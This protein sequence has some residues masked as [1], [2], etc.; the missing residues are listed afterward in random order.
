MCQYCG[1]EFVAKTTTTKYCGDN[2]A[3]RAYKERKQLEKIK[4]AK[5]ETKRQVQLPMVQLQAKEFLSIA[6]VMQ[7]CSVSRSTVNR[8][9]KTKKIG[10]AKFG[11][12]VIIKKSEL[13]KL[14]NI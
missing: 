2:C 1:N 8:L 13:N 10:S 4:A 11:R 5:D 9:I 7:M 12:R 3:K 14:F 6:E